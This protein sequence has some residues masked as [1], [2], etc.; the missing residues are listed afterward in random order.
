MKQSTFLVILLIEYLLA[1]APAEALDSLAPTLRIGSGVVE[2]GSLVRIPITLD[3]HRNFTALQF[4][5]TFEPFL[6]DKID[7]SQCL[8]KLTEGPWFAACRRQ[9]APNEDVVRY[10]IFR[11]DF[12]PIPS[13]VLGDLG[14]RAAIDAPSG[15]SPV[16]ALDCTGLGISEDQQTF[17]LKAGDYEFD[18]IVI[19]GTKP[20]IASSDPTP[21]VDL[22][23]VP[24]F[25]DNPLFRRR[26]EI[27]NPIPILAAGPAQISL[28]L[29]A[30][31]QIDGV[32]KRFIPRAG[33]VERLDC[34][35]DRVPD[36]NLDTPVSFRWYGELPDGGWIGLTVVNDV[37]R[38]TL[39]TEEASYQI[40][41]SPD[42][43]YR[44]DEID[45][46]NLPPTDVEAFARP[47]TSAGDNPA[48]KPRMTPWRRHRARRRPRVRSSSTC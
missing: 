4:D 13:G 8:T 41:G 40:A 30:G 21:I 12:Q 33:Y 16:A 48:G 24:H 14:F 42:K 25:S 5:I 18:E 26:L 32:L 38:G 6:F 11:W 22:D 47:G 23:G 10:L 44:L 37:A 17:D 43:G 39:V 29:P 3:N 2:S 1:I 9:D 34:S 7:T 20:S 36:A 35:G 28:K 45:P 31:R 19:Q 27:P 15:V 46:L